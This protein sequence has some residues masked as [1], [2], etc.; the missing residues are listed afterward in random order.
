[1][2]STIRKPDPIAA[3]TL[4][5]PT[6]SS[7]AYYALVFFSLMYFLRPEDFI[8][9]LDIIP[10]G[11]IAGGIALLALIFVVP[12]S[13]RNKIPIELKVLLLLLG[14]MILCIP[15]AFWRSGAL[16]TVVNKFSK[17]VIVAFLIYL[18]ATS[19]NEVRRLLTIQAGTVALITI[20]SVLV[21][22]TEFGRLM[23]IQKG[24]LE[25]PNDLAINVAINFPLC[26]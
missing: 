16:S 9:G 19:L 1:M 26:V 5:T 18:V 3:P 20:A 11:K 14:Q 23:G 17:G 13:R 22:R 4:E 24:I 25:N 12:S 21:H 6:R 10:L 7:L 2:R 15:F 8:P